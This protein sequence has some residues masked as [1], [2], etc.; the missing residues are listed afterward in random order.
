MRA[1]V[2]PC[3]SSHDSLKL[4]RTPH[5]PVNSCSAFEAKKNSLWTHWKFKHS[6]LWTITFLYN[7]KPILCQIAISSA[8]PLDQRLQ[9]TPQRHQKP[10]ANTCGWGWSNLPKPSEPWQN[11][12]IW[13]VCSGNEGGARKP[14]AYGWHWP[15]ERAND[16]Q[17]NASLPIAQLTL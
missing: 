12:Y 6:S 3:Q 11:Q 16:F 9:S 2:R 14:N 8:Q 4:P 13:E 1:V 10:V 7:N 5:Q 15:K 17:D